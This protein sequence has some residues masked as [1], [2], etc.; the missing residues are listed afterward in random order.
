MYHLLFVL[1]LLCGM[2]SLYAQTTWQGRVTDFAGQPLPGATIQ[3]FPSGTIVISESDG[4]FSI[5]PQIQ[6]NRIAVT[7]IGFKTWETSIRTSNPVFLQTIL[8]DDSYVFDAVD[9]LGNWAGKRSPFTY[10]NLNKNE[11]NQNNQGQDVPYVLQWTP[12]V[13]V[14]SDAGTGIGYTG[15]RI[16]GTDPTRINV[17][18]NGVPLND[19]E[20]QGVFWVDLPDFATS[21]DQIQIQRGVGTSTNGA[22]AFGGTINLSTQKLETEPYGQI[23][24]TIGSFNTRRLSL[25]AGTGTFGSGW[26]ID[27]RLSGIESDGYIDRAEANL[28]SWFVGIGHSSDKQSIRLNVFS[29]HERTYQ[30][31][32]GVPVQFAND[33]ML[34]R[35]NTA[36]LK[37]D[38]SA[39][40]N[41]VDDYTQTHYQLIYQRTLSPNWYL[42]ATGHYTRGLGYFEQYREGD[43]LS[44]YGIDPIYVGSEVISET[45]LIRRRWLDNHFYGG[46]FSLNYESDDKSNAV[47]IGLTANEYRGDHYGNII[48]SRTNIDFDRRYYFNDALKK[49]F[50]SFVKLDRRLSDVWSA[51]IDLQY[52][53]V[54]YQYA[55][56]NNAGLIFSGQYD[57]HFFNPKAGIFASFQNNSEAYASF[58]V[59]SREP[60]RDDF[61]LAV[62]GQAPRPEFLYNPELGW[63]KKWINSYIN[64]N[65]FGMFYKDQL[66]LT[67]AINDVGEYNRVNIPQSYRAGIELEGRTEWRGIIVGAAMTLS[68][69]KVITFTEFIDNWDTGG[70]EVIEHRN[71][72]LPFSPNFMANL[73]LGYKYKN[74]KVGSFGITPQISLLC[75]TVGRQYLDNSSNVASSLDPYSFAD[76][77]LSIPVK[78]NGKELISFYLWINNITDA[79]YS[80]N[81]W[82][83]RFISQGYDPRGDD[84]Y[85]R[86]E[87]NGQ[88]NLTGLFPQAGRNWLLGLHWNF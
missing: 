11:I 65:L 86:L 10:T 25:S 7:F 82:T 14:S 9:L 23:K 68:R 42:R 49:E 74:I 4:L 44:D 5:T 16:R 8:E 80:S 19:A 3:S 20:S 21:T 79:Q 27:G 63:R 58:A 39:Y 61:I 28:R 31:W 83:Y 17:T 29:G 57:Y 37:S 69:N 81:G 33:R 75:K 30:S 66:A 32:N 71:T 47:T 15:I 35:F 51:F 43:E 78:R 34:R 40:E 59:A 88:Y 56:N 45:D 38:G 36:G 24:T 50:S 41:E 2:P 54:D 70:Q 60:N 55:G 46:I 67:G 62:E 18:I 87:Q 12:S 6:D 84:P 72:D 1:T 53:Y 52:R 26:T 64:V 48:W 13:L 76:L 22:G 73:E 85:S 77:R